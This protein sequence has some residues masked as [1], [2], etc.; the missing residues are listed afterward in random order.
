VGDFAKSDRPDERS[1]A[2]ALQLAKQIFDPPS[3]NLSGHL[4]PDAATTL[5]SGLRA[6]RPSS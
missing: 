1:G 3:Q 4:L 2:L 5:P 6:R